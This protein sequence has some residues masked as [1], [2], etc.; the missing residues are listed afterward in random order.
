M[1][2]VSKETIRTICAVVQLLLN[3]IGLAILWHFRHLH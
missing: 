1:N 3:M 2:R